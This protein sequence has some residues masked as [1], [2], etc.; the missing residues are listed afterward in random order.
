MSKVW[1]WR[2]PKNGY[3]E[4]SDGYQ[5]H[6]SHSADVVIRA[7]DGAEVWLES[8]GRV[9]AKGWKLTKHPNSGHNTNDRK[10]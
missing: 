6:F 10:T 3:L 5:V 2:M 4:T 8:V 7:P 9:G 1:N